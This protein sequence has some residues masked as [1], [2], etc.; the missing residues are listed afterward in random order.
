MMMITFTVPEENERTVTEMADLIDRDALMA[1]IATSVVFSGRTSRNAEMRGANK[2]ID[3]IKA[4]PTVDAVEV[5]RCEKC[6]HAVWDGEYEMWK[7]AEDAEYDEESGVWF[8]FC[9]YH[10]GDFF[11]ADGERKDGDGNG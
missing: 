7:C 9:E 11:C 8:G 2:I 5:V 6:K 1:D 10:N 4:A 3:R